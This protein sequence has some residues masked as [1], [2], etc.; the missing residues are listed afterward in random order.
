MSASRK[1][2][3]K[4]TSIEVILETEGSGIIQIDTEIELLDEIL[5]AIA[6][7][8][9]FDLTV[10][11]RGDL[12][13][14]DHHTTEDT[15]ITLGSTLAQVIKSGIGSSMVPSGLALATAAVR[16]GEPGYQGNF[17]LQSQALGGMSLE[18]FSHFLRALAYNGRF[19]LFISAEGGDDRSRI[20]AM[21][22]ALGRAIKKAARDS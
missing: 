16:F 15:A 17:V 5:S 7:G 4:E 19:N 1:R 8:A 22:T 14:G 9:G 12:E 11:A 6:R 10:K 3:T 13:T 21:S 18:N 2:E 20:E